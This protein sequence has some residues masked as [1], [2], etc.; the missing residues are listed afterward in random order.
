[1]KKQKIFYITLATILFVGSCKQEVIKVVPPE[2]VTPVTPAKGTLDFTKFVSVGNSFVAGMQAQSLFT[3][4]QANSIPRIMA[5]QFESVGGPTTF[6]QPDIGSTNGFNPINSVF[7]SPV[8]QIP[9]FT[10]GRL[11]LFDPDGSGPRSAGPQPARFPGSSVTCP[12]AVVTPPLPSPYNTADYPTAFTGNKAALNNFGVPLTYLA[13]SLTPATGGPP[14]AKNLNPAYNVWYSRFASS[15]SPDGS[16]GSLI[17]GDAKAAAG[18]FYM[19]WLGFDDVLLYAA[20]GADGVTTG[21]FPMTSTATFTGQYNAAI[22]TLL[23]GTT[24]KGVV[25]NLPDFTSLPYFYTVPW[26]TITLDAA[27]ATT[28]T[29]N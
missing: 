18:S 3:E 12:S 13:Q 26:N 19:I 15:P 16:T 2:T 20:T 14:V 5:K 28:V 6:N 24:F 29:T 25:G 21:T 27:T 1:M 17:I 23:T 9:A 22:S 7:A 4:G 10:L 11:I 8:D